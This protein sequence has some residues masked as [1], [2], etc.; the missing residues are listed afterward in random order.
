M[1]LLIVLFVGISVGVSIMVSQYFGARNREELSADDW[2][3]YYSYRNCEPCH[4]GVILII[5]RPLLELL[6]TPESIIDW[7]EGYLLIIFLGAATGGYYNI[8][9]GVLRGLGDSVSAL[10]YLLVSC[11]TNIILDIVFVKYVGMGVNG[12]ALAT[13][14]AQGI[15]ALLCLNKLFRMKEYFDLNATH[16]K[17]SGRHVRQIFELGIPSGITQAIISL[18]MIVVQALS[19]SF[20]ETFIAANVMVQ[21]VDGFAMLP[22]FSFGMAMTTFAGQNVGAKRMD[23][24]DQGTRQGTILACNLCR[25][26]AV[27]L[28]IGRFLMSIFTITRH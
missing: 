6:G 7:S 27:L 23:R 18:S 21:R 17:L 10:L 13:V 2:K 14:I 5:T 9:S 28:V 15:S 11:V 25:D 4:Y 26:Y 19:N 8:L 16:L 20:G 22:A 3:L 24:V 12:V 1:N